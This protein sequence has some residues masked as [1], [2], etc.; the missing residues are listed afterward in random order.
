MVINIFRATA[1]TITT[2]SPSRNPAKARKPSD[3]ELWQ[4]E[5]DANDERRRRQRAANPIAVAKRIDM[6]LFKS[7]PPP[8]KTETS[9]LP[10]N[11]EIASDRSSAT[12]HQVRQII[13]LYVCSSLYG[14]RYDSHI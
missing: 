10:S 2:V 7:P 13:P 8:L 11:P 5:Q 3:F 12:G 14:F 6:Q 9:S 4:A 1:T